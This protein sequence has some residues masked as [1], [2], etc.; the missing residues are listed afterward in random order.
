MSKYEFKTITNLDKDEQGD[1]SMEYFGAQQTLFGMDK[2]DTF[3]QKDQMNVERE[4][5]KKKA[6]EEAELLSSFRASSARRTADGAAPIAK[7]TKSADSIT[8]IALSVPV[9]IVPQK[10]RRFGESIDVEKNSNA[11]ASISKKAKNEFPDNLSTTDKPEPATAVNL[12]DYPSS[13]DES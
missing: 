2:S 8:K 1:E 9:K 3:Y 12:F 13:G 4:L 5:A 11:A 7:P 6:A 10:K